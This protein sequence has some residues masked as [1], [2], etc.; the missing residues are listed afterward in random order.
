[1][2]NL[3]TILVL[4][5]SCVVQA[6]TTK[7]SG[8]FTGNGAGLTNLIRADATNNGTVGTNNILEFLSARNSDVP[9]KIGYVAMAGVGFLGGF[10]NCYQIIDYFST[11]STFAPL[12]KSGRF[13]V[14]FDVGWAATNRVGGLILANTNYF[15]DGM[16]N[17]IAYAKARGVGVSLYL[18]DDAAQNDGT[19]G[20]LGYEEQDAATLASW[21]VSVIKFDSNVIGLGFEDLF[22]WRCKKFLAALRTNSQPVHVNIS[23]GGQRPDLFPFVNTRRANAR[24]GD[25]VNY[26]LINTAIDWEITYKSQNTFGHRSDFG[27]VEFL[28]TSYG[29]TV[30]ACVALFHSLALAGTP[31]ANWVYATNQDWFYIWGDEY[32]TPRRVYT[33]NLVMVDAVALS[34]GGQG[35][36][37]Y[38]RNTVASN[39]VINASDIGL[40]GSWTWADIYNGTNAYGSSFTT[41][42]GPTNTLLLRVR[43]P[44]LQ[45]MYR[46]TKTS[47]FYLTNAASLT[48][49][50]DTVY[51]GLNVAPQSGVYEVDFAYTLIPTSAG[52]N[53]FVETAIYV[54]AFGTYPTEPN[55]RRIMPLDRAYTSGQTIS[56]SQKVFLNKGDMV[57]LQM[58]L[59]CPSGAWRVYGGSASSGSY[60]PSFS[61]S[62]I[63]Q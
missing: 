1:M 37:I 49:T 5:V 63:G 44:V 25:L 52:T 20:T 30:S 62:F 17:Y 42:V 39:I 55:T 46:A 3:I 15:P 54:N 22:V 32:S 41:S 19:I 29:R 16:S 51:S 43:N 45:S 57:I 61:I 11:N 9:S 24:F 4:S 56:A 58:A 2:K 6:A 28:T 26:S 10:T 27:G 33:N 14:H 38:N 23:Y 53:D 21:G 59:T 40:T 12:V 35:V 36:S 8:A 13:V 18:Q 47:D 48:I 60:R 7:Y 34:D 50:N 31:P